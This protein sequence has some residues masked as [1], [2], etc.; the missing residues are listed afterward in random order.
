MGTVWSR[1]GLL[2]ILLVPGIASAEPPAR[3]ERTDV[4]PRVRAEAALETVEKWRAT[5]ARIEE[6][7]ARVERCL[8]ASG[9]R[10]LFAKPLADLVRRFSGL[11]G[12]RLLTA[13]NRHYNGFPYVPDRAAGRSSD[14]W[15]SPLVFLQ[16]S[17]DCEDFA[18]A[19]Y[20]TLRLLGVSETAMTI[21]LLRNRSD[22]RD[23]AV[24]V[25]WDGS[26]SIV[27]DNLR[28]LAT[29]EDY[30][31]Y[32]PLLALKSEPSRSRRPAPTD[33]VPSSGARERPLH[34]LQ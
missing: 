16:R 32:R 13:V 18:F 27:L 1:L 23:H 24:L 11:S 2:A 29:L 12:R 5:L 28:E 8:D 22:G 4:L 31:G 34:A 15:L 7:R 21:L 33:A 14:M 6:D 20:L 30:G 3:L 10:D 25:V 26:R 19:K 9:C 17:G